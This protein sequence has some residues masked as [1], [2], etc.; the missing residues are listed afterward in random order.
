MKKNTFDIVVPLDF[1]KNRID[2]FLQSK[3]KEFSRTRLQSLIRDGQV[4]LN[5]SPIIDSS[6]KIKKDDEIKINFPEPKKTHI[7]PNDIPL[8]VLA[9]FQWS[10]SH[11]CSTTSGSY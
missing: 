11:R 3:L 4:K 2:K 9:I 8:D 10:I 1:E 6:K 7:E 5:N